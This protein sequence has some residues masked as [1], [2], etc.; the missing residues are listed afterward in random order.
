M[1]NFNHERLMIAYAANRLARVC[2][3]DAMKYRCLDL[4]A[5]TLLLTI[6]LWLIAMHI[7]AKYLALNSSRPM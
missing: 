3:E 2:I 5:Y 6:S 7:H 4:P 1:T